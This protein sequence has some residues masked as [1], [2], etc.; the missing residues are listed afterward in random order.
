MEFFFSTTENE[1]CKWNIS[2]FEA[3]V[4]HLKRISMT[5]TFI[6]LNCVIFIAFLVYHCTRSF[7]KFSTLL[8]IL[9]SFHSV[10]W[11]E[12]MLSAWNIG[13]FYFRNINAASS[14]LEEC[15]FHISKGVYCSVQ[16]YACVF[17]LF[18]LSFI[19][20]L[21]FLRR[22]TLIGLAYACKWRYTTAPNKALA[23]QWNNDGIQL[24]F[25]LLFWL[26][27]KKKC[28]QVTYL[29]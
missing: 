21:A 29:H 24:G 6:Y 4:I 13:L 7:I 19:F 23:F 11:F 1:K 18:I 5:S 3:C 22:A 2:S 12:T 16:C 9:Y 25:Y 17:I 14:Q 27:G 10:L 28:C 15:Q 8:F 20:I 26:A